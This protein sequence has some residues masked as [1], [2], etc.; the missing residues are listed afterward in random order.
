MNNAFSR[1]RASNL[2]EDFVKAAEA[3]ADRDAALDRLV[4]PR[5]DREGT[6]GK[7]ADAPFVI[8]LDERVV[9]GECDHI[10]PYV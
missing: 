7:G 8:S 2:Q 9:T 1:L 6:V 5:L 10:A 4:M 3:I